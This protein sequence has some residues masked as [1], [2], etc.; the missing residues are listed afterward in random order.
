MTLDEA[1]RK[2]MSA[3]FIIDLTLEDDEFEKLLNTQ[4]QKLTNTECKLNFVT[5]EWLIESYSELIK[6]RQAI[7][8]RNVA[9][10]VPVQNFPEQSQNNTFQLLDG[11]FHD[12]GRKLRSTLKN[13]FEIELY[14]FEVR[15][16]YEDNTY[17]YTV[18]LSKDNTLEH[19]CIQSV[20][21]HTKTEQKQENLE[22]CPRCSGPTH[23]CRICKIIHG[24]E[25]VLPAKYFLPN[26]T[27][28]L[29]PDSNQ[30]STIQGV[31]K[32]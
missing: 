23:W 15:P 3:E 21:Q 10:F 13:R 6:C 4:I 27:Y 19:P 8:L 30:L 11:Q 2:I 25:N 14:Q 28:P 5:Q 12:L 26:L 16:M 20:N 32:K 7:K 22:Q 1:G 18:N 24:I 17:E 29:H 9:C 31:T